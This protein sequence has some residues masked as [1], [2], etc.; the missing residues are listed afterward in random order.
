MRAFA[1]F[2]SPAFFEVQEGKQLAKRASKSASTH[3]DQRQ[4][5]QLQANCRRA[6]LQFNLFGVIG[7]GL[8]AGM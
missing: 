4:L 3:S 5:L 2:F 7:L 6:S 1:R 8:I